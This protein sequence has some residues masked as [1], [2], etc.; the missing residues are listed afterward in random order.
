MLRHP[1]ACANG[2][3][4]QVFY[5]ECRAD[6][7]CRP[8]RGIDEQVSKAERLWVWVPS[9]GEVCGRCRR[10]TSATPDLTTWSNEDTDTHRRGLGVVG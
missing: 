5:Y 4:D 10:G 1:S 2:R 7:A 8:Q 3:R 6:R 9:D